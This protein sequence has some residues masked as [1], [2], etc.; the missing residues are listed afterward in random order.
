MFLMN[1]Q[2]KLI[3]RSLSI[4]CKTS[5]SELMFGM[6][7]VSSFQIYSENARN[8]AFKYLFM[9]ER[10]LIF[11]EKLVREIERDIQIV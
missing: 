11:I 8:N 5:L 2:H 7:S 6:K 10:L 3:R 9:D 4:I 1:Y